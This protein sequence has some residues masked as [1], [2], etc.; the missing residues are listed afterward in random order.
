MC[1]TIQEIKSLSLLVTETC[2]FRKPEILHDKDSIRNRHMYMKYRY[3]LTIRHGYPPFGSPL[4]PLWIPFQILLCLD[5]SILIL[6]KKSL[7]SMDFIQ[8]Q[9]RNWNP[10]KEGF[11]NPCKEGFWNPCK[12]DNWNPKKTIQLS[13][14]FL[15]MIGSKTLIP[16]FQE[17]KLFSNYHLD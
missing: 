7:L 6:V 4:D 5:F 8:K 9:R 1:I 17:K 2:L 13:F 3:S 14:G 11:W 12:E 16:L 15:L 10:C